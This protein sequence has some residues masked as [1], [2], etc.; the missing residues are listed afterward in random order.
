[1][2]TCSYCN[3]E[4]RDHVGCT[5]QTYSDFRDGIE[6][7]R[8]PNGEDRDCHDCGCPP[9]ELHHPGC[10][11]ERCPGCGGQAISCGCASSDDDDDEDDR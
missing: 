9:G 5:T 11:D 7:K 8:I 6:R 1:M 2:A 10:D 4:M 3:R